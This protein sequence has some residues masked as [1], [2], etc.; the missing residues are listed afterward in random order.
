L[1][2]GILGGDQLGLMLAESARKLDT[3]VWVLEQ[4]PRRPAPSE[5]PLS[6]TTDWRRRRWTLIRT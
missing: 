3:P 6:V 4:G 5:A 1:R 2:V